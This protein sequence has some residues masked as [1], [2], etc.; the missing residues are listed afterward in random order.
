MTEGKAGK[1]GFAEP[2]LDDLL[3]DPV[4]HAM[5]RRDRVSRDELMTIISGA[6]LRLGLRGNAAR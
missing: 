6:R 1:C 3:E 2:S 5:L 4:L